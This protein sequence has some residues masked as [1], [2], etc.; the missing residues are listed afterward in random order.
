MNKFI[1]PLAAAA[2]LITGNLFAQEAALSN[3]GKQHHVDVR[4]RE[5]RF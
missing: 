4:L 1:Y 2:A 5:D 3:A